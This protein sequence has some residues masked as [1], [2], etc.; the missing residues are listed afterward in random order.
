MKFY[1]VCWMENDCC[2]SKVFKYRKAAEKFG[3]K[4]MCDHDTAIDISTFIDT[5]EI[6][7]CHY[8]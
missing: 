7:I 2:K 6:E 1:V 8:N 5:T 3:F 4:M